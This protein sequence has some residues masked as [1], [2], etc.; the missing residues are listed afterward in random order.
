MV[1]EECEE[2]GAW[3]GGMADE[4]VLL[5]EI[6][7]NLARSMMWLE[8]RYYGPREPRVSAHQ[9]RGNYDVT[10]GVMWR[11]FVDAGGNARIT[12][13]YHG[14]VRADV[15][16]AFGV[17]HWTECLAERGGRAECYDSD[18]EYMAG[19]IVEGSDSDSPAVGDDC[20]KAAKLA[21]ARLELAC[22]AVVGAAAVGELVITA[23]GAGGALVVGG[24]TGPSVA[25]TAVTLE[26]RT[27]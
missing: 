20:A 4:G 14:P 16:V 24:P 13:E 25:A 19:E 23:G 6:L 10:E 11:T 15:V 21:S 2:L 27:G 18:G 8:S 1:G 3:E 17:V 22:L 9:A 5:V 26:H 12:T 7:P